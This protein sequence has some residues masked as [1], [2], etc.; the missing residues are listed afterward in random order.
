[1]PAAV[2]DLAL[3][4]PVVLADADRLRWSLRPR[5]R[6]RRGAAGTRR[7]GDVQRDR[8]AD[9]PSRARDHRR[10]PV[11]RRGH[12]RPR[13]AA[14]L[15]RDGPA[16]EGDLHL[17][18]PQLS[19][20]DRPAPGAPPGPVPLLVPRGGEIASH[21]VLGALRL[22]AQL[23]VGALL[24]LRGRPG[25][26]PGPHR[27]RAPRAVALP[28]DLLRVPALAHLELLGPRGDAV[29]QDLDLVAAGG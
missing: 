4:E 1:P 10:P 2:P 7:S 3:R 5:R 25:L 28:Q 6:L 16:P 13:G 26:V 22:Q 24:R 15:H 9:R 14:P 12:R 11:A 23:A 29:Q 17:R 20:A 21:D 27:P 19:A 18:P 8:E